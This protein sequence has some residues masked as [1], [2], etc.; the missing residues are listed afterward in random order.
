M[1]PCFQ[2]FVTVPVDPS[3]HVS[4]EPAP[5]IKYGKLL[6][7]NQRNRQSKWS[8]S[9]YLLKNSHFF[10]EN[11]HA[12]SITSNELI[13]NSKPNHADRINLES[14][15]PVNSLDDENLKLIKP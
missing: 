8:E 12:I 11:M 14:Y 3:I 5:A 7:I 6:N 13:K 15:L 2:S 4:G 1:L 9:D 10:W